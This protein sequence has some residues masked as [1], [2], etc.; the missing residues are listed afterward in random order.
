MFSA[1][2]CR[3]WH[4]SFWEKDKTLRHRRR[5]TTDKDRSKKLFWAFGSS[6]LETPRQSEWIETISLNTVSTDPGLKLSFQSTEKFLNVHKMLTDIH[7]NPGFRHCSLT[8]QWAF[9]PTE[10]FWMADT[11]QWPFGVLLIFRKRNPFFHQ[12]QFE[13]RGVLVFFLFFFWG[14]GVNVCVFFYWITKFLDN[15]RNIIWLLS[16]YAPWRPHCYKNQSS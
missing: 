3:N 16:L 7:W 14:G 6:E 4:G 1:K 15:Q 5:R 12:I 9:S 13:L 2:F 11:L 8:F 10:R